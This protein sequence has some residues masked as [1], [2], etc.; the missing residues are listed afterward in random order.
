MCV[1]LSVLTSVPR[2][3]GS[4]DSL[5]FSAHGGK[6]GTTTFVEL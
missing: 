1:Y 6:A 5:F 3:K 4:H 2:R